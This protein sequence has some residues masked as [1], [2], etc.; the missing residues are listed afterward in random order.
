MAALLLAIVLT[1]IAS[2]SSNIGKAF[3]KEASRHLPPLDLS[4]TRVVGEYAGSKRFKTGLALDFGGTARS[5][6][7]RLRMDW[8][9]G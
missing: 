9:I 7:A 8:L 6:H 2:S 1:V 4:N 3:Q 5:L